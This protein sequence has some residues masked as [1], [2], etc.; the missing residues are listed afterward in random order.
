VFV[1]SLFRASK[2]FGYV[3]VASSYPT[4]ASESI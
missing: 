2:P 3:V 4:K 1:S